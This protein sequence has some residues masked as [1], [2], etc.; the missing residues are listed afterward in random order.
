VHF[1]PTLPLNYT[2]RKGIF[3]SSFHFYFQKQSLLVRYM[4]TVETTSPFNMNRRFPGFSV[5]FLLR[6]IDTKTGKSKVFS[7]A[8]QTSPPSDSSMNSDALDP[9]ARTVVPIGLDFSNKDGSFASH[10]LQQKA[11]KRGTYWEY[12]PQDFSL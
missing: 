2:C 6:E 4:L 1:Y 10:W 12:W 7:N 8:L 9:K 5:S 11:R 3:F